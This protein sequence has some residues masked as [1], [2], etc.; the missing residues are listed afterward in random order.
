MSSRFNNSIF[1]KFL[2][3]CILANSL[4]IAGEENIYENFDSHDFSG[5]FSGLDWQNNEDAIWTIDLDAFDGGSSARSGIITHNQTSSIYTSAEILYLPGNLQFSYKL[6]TQDAE[7]SGYLHGHL[8]FYANNFLKGEWSGVQDWTE[9]SFLFNPGV[10]DFKWEYSKYSEPGTCGGEFLND[11]SGDGDCCA[12]AWVGDGLCDGVDQAYGCDLTCHDNDQGDCSNLSAEI[13]AVWIDNINIKTHEI[14]VDAGPATMSIDFPHDAI[15]NGEVTFD[16]TNSYP[17]ENAYLSEATIDWFQREMKWYSI[18]DLDNVLATGPN[19]TITLDCTMDPVIP[20]MCTGEYDIVLKV[21]FIPIG[22]TSVFELEDNVHVSITEP[23]QPPI[24]VGDFVENTVYIPNFTGIPGDSTTV[25]LVSQFINQVTITDQ[26]NGMEDPLSLIW[27]NSN[28]DE[29]SPPLQTLTAGEYVYFLTALDPYGS[30]AVITIDLIMVE[31]NEIPIVDIAANNGLNGENQNTIENEEVLLFGSVVDG[32]NCDGDCTDDSGICSGIGCD[33]YTTEETCSAEDECSWIDVSYLWSCIQADGTSVNFIDDID[34]I[35]NTSFIAPTVSSNSET[36]TVTCTLQATD[37]FQAINNTNSTS[38]P[39][40]IIVF[41]NNQPPIIEISSVLRPYLNEGSSFI[42]DYLELTSNDFISV[43]DD[44]DDIELICTVNNCIEIYSGD[45]YSLE[46]LTITPDPDF[47]TEISIPIRI[48]DGFTFGEDELYNNFSE[49][50]YLIIDVKGIND[51]PALEGPTNIETDE[52]LDVEIIGL[53]VSDADMG[54]FGEIYKD[55]RLQFDLSAVNGT[56]SLSNIFNIICAVDDCDAEWYSNA[57]ILSFTANP[58]NFNTA[59]S[60]L[61]FHPAPNYF[62]SD[63]KITITVNDQGN[64]G[65]NEDGDAE[66]LVDI[67]E[68]LIDVIEVND[69]PILTILPPTSSTNEDNTISIGTINDPAIAFD[70]ID[71]LD[72]QFKMIISM[73]NS[74]ISLTGNLDPLIFYS[75]TGT[76]DIE[77]SFGGSK[78]DILNA[79]TTIIFIPEDN[80]DEMATGQIKIDDLGG[81]ANGVPLYDL[82]EF[83]VNISAINDPPEIS[84]PG[85]LTNNE[86]NN[87]RIFNLSVSD[88]DAS[89]PDNEVELTLSSND[90]MISLAPIEGLGLVLSSGDGELDPLIVIRGEISNINEALSGINGFSFQGNPNHNGPTSLSIEINDLGNTGEGNELED[91]AIIQ[92]NLEPVNDPPVNQY[93]LSGVDSPPQLSVDG[94]EISATSGAWNDAIDTD[95]SGITTEISFT[96]QWQRNSNNCGVDYDNDCNDGLIFLEGNPCGLDSECQLLEEY[97]VDIIGEIELSYTIQNIDASR[98]IRIEVTATDDGVGLPS[99]QSTTVASDFHY[100]DNSAPEVHIDSSDPLKIETLEDIPFIL[101]E[102]GVLNEQYTSDPDDDNLYAYIVSE[103]TNGEVSLDLNGSF[104]YEPND[105]FNGPDSF[106][107][108]IYDGALYADKN[109]VISINVIPVN[110]SPVFTSSGDVELS[111]SSQYSSVF[112]W[113][114][115][116]DDGDPELIQLLEFTL[117]ALNPDLFEIQPTINLETGTLSF[118]VFDSLNGNSNVLISLKDNGG[119]GVCTHDGTTPCTSDASQCDGFADTTCTGNEGIDEIAH[120]PFNINIIPINDSPFFTAEDTIIVLED[121]GEYS[122]FSWAINID[123]GD[124]ELDQEVYFTIISNDNPFLFVED[125]LPLI[126]DSGKI[127]FTLTDNKSGFAQVVI[128][129][130]DEGLYYPPNSNISSEHTLIINVVAVNDTPVWTVGE[131]IEILEDAGIQNIPNYITGISDGDPEATQEQELAFNLISVS[132]PSLFS[133]MPTIDEAGTL[134]FSISEDVNESSLIENDSLLVYFTLSDDGGTGV[135]THDGTTPCTSDASQCDGFADTTCTDNGGVDETDRQSFRII[136]LPVNDPPIFVLGTLSQ[137]ISIVEKNE[138]LY[139]VIEIPVWADIPIN[140][141]SQEITYELD[142]DYAF[143]ESG[144]AFAT[145]Y[146]DQNG[147]IRIEKILN[148]NGSDIITVTAND[149]GGFENGGEEEYKQ[150]F[151]IIVHALNDPPEFMIEDPFGHQIVHE[152]VIEFNEDFELLSGADGNYNMILLPAP[153]DE[154]AQNITFSCNCDSIDFAKVSINSTTGDITFKNIL[155]SNGKITLQITAEDNGDTENEGDGNENSFTQFYTLIINAVNDVPSFEKGDDQYILEDT[156]QIIIP[157][158]A[159]DI[160]K[161]PLNETFQELSFLVTTNNDA[162][163]K[164]SQVPIVDVIS[165]DLIYQIADNL[166]GDIQVILS[167]K[168]DGGIEFGGVDESE[169]QTF[170]IYVQTINDPPSFVLGPNIDLEFDE[171]GIGNSVENWVS[172]ISKGSIDEVDQ[173]LSFNITS[174]ASD[175]TIFSV[176]PQIDEES[177]RI[178]YSVNPNFNGKAK[179]TVN[180]SDDG[181]RENGGYDTSYDQQFDIWVHQINDLPEVFEVHSRVFSYAKDT[182]TFYFD[183]DENNDTTNVFYRLP[184]QNFVP[185][186]QPADLLKFSWVKSS[187]IDTSP[188]LNFDTIFSLYYRLEAIPDGSSK[189]FVLKDDIVSEMN[190]DSISIEIDMTSRFPVYTG[191]FNH[192]YMP[193]QSVDSLNTYI[194]EHLDITGVTEY[195]WRVIGQNYSND[196]KGNDSVRTVLSDVDLKIDLELPTAEMAFFQS[197]LYSEYY[198]LYFITNEE[199]IDSVARVWIDFDTYT[200]NLF[201]SKMSDSL[202][203]ISSTFVSTGTVKYN[204]QIR[205]KRLNLG[206]SLD[207]VKYEIL[208]P[209]LPRTVSSP[210]NILELHVPVNAVEYDTPLIISAS[211]IDGDLSVNSMEIVSREYQIT[212]NSMV[213]LKSAILSFTLSEDLT[214]E[215]SYKYQIIKINDYNIEELRTEFDGKSFIASIMSS[216]NYAVAYNSDAIEPLPENFAFGNIYPNPFNPSTTIEFAIPDENN[217]TI[218][219]Y[220][221]RGQHV[222]NLLDININPGYHAVVWSGLDNAGRIVPSGIYFVNIK[223][224]NQLMSKKVIFLK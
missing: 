45:N 177:G 144:N 40:S 65:L 43:A 71:S 99:E 164:N 201:P 132:Y 47:Y 88:V 131:T 176:F 125:G 114:T 25:N 20:N 34:N 174:S 196:Y 145:L 10:Y 63:G 91:V 94:I 160:I 141:A 62:G 133:E 117:T 44:D 175:S 140:E 42:I 128:V 207:T 158:W 26:S 220:N 119:T 217:V 194:S 130:Q 224:A 112:N 66:E 60:T 38:E 49:I 85:V 21:S 216:G 50:E 87:F 53:S 15:P 51:S 154:S 30:S 115:D 124:I 197:E 214:E 24:M 84:A 109:A 222:L 137:Q 32:N 110:D 206:R 28:G 82:G 95:I 19:P 162:F 17:D 126:D 41:N 103:P 73:Q 138:D 22:Q 55:A 186:E 150:T 204:F 14:E 148:G 187:D 76:N 147:T 67:F 35:I 209:E 72:D 108:R 2:I 146:I 46:G 136:V 37:P 74:F 180:L 221:L 139:T 68:I 36:E 118:A 105:N 182:T 23:N 79:V 149:S 198:D 3:V 156:G 102:P 52:D 104:I 215:P 185:E 59:V 16:G 188:N 135:C 151:T 81:N 127:T 31:V 163:F 171:D 80:Y 219:I 193:T 165:G 107:C 169:S 106:V 152:E 56:M 153:D 212:A 122:Q 210:D 173:I 189:I 13:D 111:E 161:G 184:Y 78:T 129:L 101:D 96:Y 202:Y 205:D 69:P 211:N 70:D 33:G 191:V 181:G 157:S 83:F 192:D 213:L 155:D 18:D 61:T 183:V 54:Y 90:G 179:F 208:I 168:D 92:I 159:T 57:A 116:I 167:L 142:Q 98:Y 113:A 64:F 200:Q 97:W 58:A 27:S 89:G 77:V 100:I 199:T 5:D 134:T 195:S 203:H 29:I 120:S 75:G 190:E 11:C 123:D 6:E 8:K 1:F 121:S 86:D 218:D 39:I 93:I 223:F 4:L 166:N 7:M 12:E 9:V 143:N 178:E 172:N 170:N 48:S